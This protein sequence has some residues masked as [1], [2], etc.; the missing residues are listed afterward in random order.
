MARIAATLLLAM[1]LA[2]PSTAQEEQEVN[3]VFE[4]LDKMDFLVGAWRTE[5]T[6]VPGGGVMIGDLEYRR[7]LGGWWIM[8]D[9]CGR[10]PDGSENRLHGLYTYFPEEGC[11]RLYGFGGSNQTFTLT[12]RWADDERLVFASDATGD[13]G[14]PLSRIIYIKMAEGVRQENDRLGPDGEYEMTLRTSYERRD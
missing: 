14:K 10:L 13:D 4:A 9:F 5:S 3:A 7:A 1:F 2:G 6:F 11:Y 8:V 12:G